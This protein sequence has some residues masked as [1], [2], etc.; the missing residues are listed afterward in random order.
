M[1]RFIDA[2][3]LPGRTPAEGQ[4]RIHYLADNGSRAELMLPLLE[5]TLLLRRL[6]IILK[7]A[8]V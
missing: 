3:Y 5:A 8:D 7:N 4:V 2:I 6:E 1:V